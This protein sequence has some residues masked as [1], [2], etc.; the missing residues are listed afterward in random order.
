MRKIIIAATLISTLLQSHALRA[1]ELTF[2]LGHAEFNNEIA[3]SGAYFSAEYLG[4]RDWQVW[5]FDAGLGVAGHI[6]ETGD[7]FFGGGLQAQRDIG[8]GWFIEASLMPGLYFENEARNDLGS[9]FEIRSLIG[10]G[11]DLRGGKRL[12]L[13]L[14]HMS[15]ASLARENPGLNTIT[16]RLHMPLGQRALN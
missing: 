1:Q 4:P 14:T 13:A 12:S 9:N 6:H 11:R 15:N 16:L 7:V 5:G 8:R 10:I 3:E 2:G